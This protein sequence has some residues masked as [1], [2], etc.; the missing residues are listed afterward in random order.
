MMIPPPQTT[1]AISSNRF[2]FPTPISPQHNDNQKGHSLKLKKPINNNKL[3]TYIQKT[4]TQIIPDIRSS[5][6]L[7]KKIP[8]KTLIPPSQ[9]SMQ[10]NIAISRI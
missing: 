8:I 3:N 4:P 1:K 2:I 9:S 10:N 6:E 7:P 5:H